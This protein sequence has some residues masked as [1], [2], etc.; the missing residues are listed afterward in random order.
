MREA[1]NATES[2]VRLASKFA[3]VAEQHFSQFK[4][5]GN[6]SLLASLPGQRGEHVVQI[7]L[8]DA[9]A[10]RLRDPRGP[11]SSRKRIKRCK[12]R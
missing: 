1:V 3:D 5:E 8:Q 10:E 6:S 2:R 7:N 11:V 12:R 4:I 9:Q